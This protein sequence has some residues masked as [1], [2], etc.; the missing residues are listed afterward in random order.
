MVEFS[1]VRS[2][3]PFPFA[4]FHALLF[5]VGQMNLSVAEHC[6]CSLVAFV[7]VGMLRP[8]A[9]DGLC[10]VER[11]LESVPNIRIAMDGLDTEDSAIL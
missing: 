9:S 3:V 5:L 7:A 10:L 2:S 8:P 11:F 6:R 4:G 1:G